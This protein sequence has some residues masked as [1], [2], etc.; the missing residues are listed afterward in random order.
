MI[1]LRCILTLFPSTTSFGSSYKPSSGWL[2]FLSKVKYTVSNVIVIV[3]Y[4]IS[5]NICKFEIK[6]IPL[7][8]QFYFKFF[9]YVIRD[10]VGKNN[11]S[12]AN[13]IFF[14]VSTCIFPIHW[15]INTNQCTS[16]STIYDGW[17]FNSGNYLFTT[18]TK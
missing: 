6:L 18:D 1:L 12:I 15:M 3:T 2:L 17:N 14:N 5:Y 10:L 4:E 7:W 16:H 11:N 13:C 9:I 8:N